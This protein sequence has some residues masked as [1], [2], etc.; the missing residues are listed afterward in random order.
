MLSMRRGEVRS[1]ER[2]IEGSVEGGQVELHYVR[3]ERR[4]APR[5]EKWTKVDGEAR[6]KRLSLYNDKASENRK[7][8]S[9]TWGTI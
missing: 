3:D 6:K 4:V 8:R 9:P 2:S 5:G 1:I 7:A